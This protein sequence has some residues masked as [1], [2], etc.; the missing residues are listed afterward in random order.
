MRV[1][2]IVDSA[3]TG[4]IR[5]F[6][7]A[8]RI[9]NAMDIPRHFIDRPVGNG[10]GFTGLTV[11]T[12]NPS[13]LYGNINAIGVFENFQNNTTALNS[14]IPRGGPTPSEN[15]CQTGNANI[16]TPPPG[17]WCTNPLEPNDPLLHGS[18]GIYSDATSIHSNGWSDA[19]MFITGF[20]YLYRPQSSL[21]RIA[22]RTTIKA[23]WLTG[24]PRTGAGNN[25]LTGQIQ[26]GNND[27]PDPEGSMNFDNNTD[28]GLHN[29]P[30]FAEDFG[31]ADHSRNFNYNGSFIFQFFSH[32]GNG[33]FLIGG[34]GNYT[35]P[36]PR[37]WNF[38]TAFLVPTGVPAGTPFFFFYKNGSYR[39]VFLENNPN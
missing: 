23:A 36:S 6:R 7:R 1:W 21:R 37:N 29:F 10:R 2:R 5:A 3:K 33:P 8:L 11:V 12:E 38:D 28:G 26:N 27:A 19:R 15:Y 9:T 30:R 34:D 22:V 20:N 4:R 25:N 31:G 14:R 39:Q 24:A 35:P 18:M 17:D 16:A 13:Y 32:Q